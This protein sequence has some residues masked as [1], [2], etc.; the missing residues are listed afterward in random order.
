MKTMG[1]IAAAVVAVLLAAPTSQA[2]EDRLWGEVI[3]VD[4]DVYEG[5]IRWDRNEVGWADLLNGSREID[6]RD[7]ADWEYAAGAEP[8]SR[9]R[10]IEFLGIRISWD[11]DESLFPSSG[12]SGIRFGHID[13]LTVTDR[14]G[15][16]LRLR[17]GEM[18]EFRNG[19]TDIGTDIREIL[20]EDPDRGMVELGWEDLDEISFREAPRR[21]RP[22]SER[23][24]GTVEDRRGNSYTGYISWDLDEVLTE[25]IL[26]GDEDGRDREVPFSQIGAIE[27]TGFRGSLVTLVDGTE[28]RLEGSN[29]VD[30]GHRGVQVSDPAVGQIEIPWDEFEAIRFHRPELSAHRSDF[31]GGR[32]L[33]GTVE[34]ES[35]DRFTGFIRWDA[36]EAYTWEILDGSSR[37]IVY[38]IEFG[39]IERIER[40]SFF[41]ADVTL[42]DGR[43]IELEDSNGVDEG[44]RGIFIET[45]SGEKI[46]VDWLAFRSVTFDG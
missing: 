22:R 45:E 19:S 29:D 36:D 15:A 24:Y 25:D 46:I 32:R 4:G 17:S 7:R 37:D 9:E 1:W 14:Q 41:G 21:A 11:D 42:R 6:W 20:V 35:G 2:Q 5:F 13:R 39:E 27:R 12:E 16:M 40:N 8:E 23:L 33:Y 3:T 38:D 26:D 31:D 34:T 44:N 18:V 43:V 28:M 30:D 10:S